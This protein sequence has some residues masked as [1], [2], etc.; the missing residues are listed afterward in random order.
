MN[1]KEDLYVMGASDAVVKQV[2]LLFEKLIADI[3]ENLELSPEI[4]AILNIGLEKL[5]QQLRDK[6]LL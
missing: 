2:G 6:W 5:K 4:D 3:P 1:W